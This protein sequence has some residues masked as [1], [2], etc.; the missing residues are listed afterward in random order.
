MLGQYDDMGKYY[1]LA[2]DYGKENIN[3]LFAMYCHR[4]HRWLVNNEKDGECIQ[5]LEYIT[6]KEGKIVLNFRSPLTN[7]GVYLQH[8]D[9]HNVCVEDKVLNDKYVIKLIQKINMNKQQ[10]N[11][12]DCALNTN[13]IPYDYCPH[14]LCINCYIRLVEKNKFRDGVCSTCVKNAMINP[15]ILSNNNDNNMPPPY[16]AKD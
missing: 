15:D 14:F 9:K 10:I 3:L 2:F 8:K 6:R 13:C 5:N 12:Q 16:V 7:F 1:K 4:K 11:C